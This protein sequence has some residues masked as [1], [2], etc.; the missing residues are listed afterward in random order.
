[1]TKRKFSTFA[2]GLVV[3]LAMCGC[4]HLH[5][6]QVGQIDNRDDTVAV[7]FEILM[8]ESGVSTEEI[9]AIARASQSNAGDNLGAVAAIVSLFQMGPRTGNP[10]YD[11]HYAE[12]LIYQIYEKCP[13]GHVSDLQSIRETRKYPVISGEIVKLT[14]VCKHP[15]TTASRDELKGDTP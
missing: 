14:G 3:A 5:H 12:R 4:A 13:S 8:S 11:R 7:P 10:V 2:S 15:K 9:G 6:I 1:M